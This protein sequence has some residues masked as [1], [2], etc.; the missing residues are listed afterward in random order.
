MKPENTFNENGKHW[1]V[2]F[3]DNKIL[4]RC[5]DESYLI[6]KTKVDTLPEEAK[7]AVHSVFILQNY[8]M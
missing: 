5:E 4:V 8:Y 1:T 6:D 7:T 3:Q 2:L